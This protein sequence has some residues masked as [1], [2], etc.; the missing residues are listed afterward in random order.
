[1]KNW[2]TIRWMAI[3]PVAISFAGPALAAV[4]VDEGKVATFF[5]ATD[6]AVAITLTGGFPNAISSS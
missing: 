4:S 3:M 5:A 2:S 1:M 6:G